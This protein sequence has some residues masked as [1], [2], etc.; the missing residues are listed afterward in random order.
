VTNG[1]ARADAV[2]VGAG[3][4]G[5]T[6]AYLLSVAGLDITILERESI[7]RGATGHGHGIVSLVGKDFRPGPHLEL[8]VQA[9]RMYGEL[10]E[11]LHE[12]S[13][14]DPMYH[15][16]PGISFAVVEEEERIFRDFMEREDAR[17][18]VDMQWLTVDECR[19]IE[20]LLTE[21]AIGGVYH[22]HGQVDAY[23]LALAAV[24]AVERRGGRMVTGEA[25]GLVRKA[26]RVVGVEHRH[27]TIACDHVVLAAGAWV[28]RAAEWLG[29]PVPVRPLHGEVLHVRLRG[30]PVQAFILTARH[31]PIL[32]KRDGTLMVGSVGGVTMSGMDV[33]AKHVF[34][35]LDDTP[36]N[37][38][39]VPTQAGRDTMIERAVRVMPALAEAE[40]TAH[41]AGVRPLSADR[42]PLIGPVPGLEGAW[43]A[44]G[45][46]TKGIHLAPVTARMIADY[47][48]RGRPD[49]DIPAEAFLPERFAVSQPS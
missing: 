36:P 46:G 42:M 13:G 16:L 45:H 14:V 30:D 39:E 11:A 19:A 35:P 9:A 3:V 6:I 49:P 2:V 5:T 31:G 38:D 22:S 33:D 37:F 24:A 15:E 17:H 48:T 18:L 27:G 25:T 7:G 41:L 21:D 12:D 40:L 32:P 1:E 43:L 28:G 23:R 34:D 44:T 10:C 8:G 26:G 4:V 20:P 29:T 47:L